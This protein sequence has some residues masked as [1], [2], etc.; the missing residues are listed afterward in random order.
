MDCPALRGDPASPCHRKVQCDCAVHCGRAGWLAGVASLCLFMVLLCVFATSPIRIPTDSRW[1]VHTA[2]SFAKGRFGDLTE[3]L[4]IITKE[5]FYAIE[6]R[7]GRP[8]TRYPI[9]TSLLAMPAVVVIAIFHPALA[10]ELRDSIPARTE[11]FIASLVGAIASVV[12]FWLML[13]QFHSLAV[14]LVST[15]IFALSTSIWSTATRAL[16]Q[17]GPLVLMLVI[18]MLIL[19]RAQRRPAL[20][21]Y[22]ALPLAFAYVIRPTAIVPLAVLSLY[23]LLFHRAWFARYV[24]WGLLIAVPWALY[25]FSI[26]G[27]PL[28]PYYKREAFSATTRFVAGLLGNLFSPSRGLFVFSPVL[29]FALS[30]FVLALRDRA[31]RPL[32]ISYG[33][34][35]V[36]HSIIVGAASMW[37]AG[38]SFGPRFMT[39]VVPFLV[40]F[41]AFNF[42]L[43]ETVRPRTQTAISTVIVLL[44]LASAVIHAQGAIRYKTW[45]W[46]YIPD[47]IDSNPSRAWD[48]SDPQFARS[49]HR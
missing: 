30:G 41:T 37:W 48:W 1:S 2:M 10:D 24:C 49:G 43:P 8:R 36:G 9:G 39:D 40:Y 14:A 22:V 21:Q 3:Y 15:V 25:N 42:R 17:H 32:H 5:Q 4:P 44:A 23:V 20:M 33:V 28:P 31:Q 27:L 47:N 19:R 29:L 26:Y 46:N 11:Q 18:A 45:E 16:W 35:I 34:I 12:F 13:S 6:Y 7:D 38:H